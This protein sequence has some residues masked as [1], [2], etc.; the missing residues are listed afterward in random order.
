[1]KQKQGIFTISTCDQ[2]ISSSMAN[3]TS[4]PGSAPLDFD[5][6]D[7]EKNVSKY[8]QNLTPKNDELPHYLD[9]EKASFFHSQLQCV[10][11]TCSSIALFYNVW[12]TENPEGKE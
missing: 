7:D 11:I 1:M 8:Q 2:S 10:S 6:G 3:L 4:F 9:W 12:S 5:L